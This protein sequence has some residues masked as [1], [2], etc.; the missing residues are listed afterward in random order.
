[1]VNNDLIESINNKTM[2][3]FRNIEYQSGDKV[4]VSGHYASYK[5]Q[6][7]FMVGK[8]YLDKKGVPRVYLDINPNDIRQTN[9]I[10]LN[11]Y[12][13]ISKI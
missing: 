13:D 8:V 5:S 11:C 6:Y 9:G 7:N 1:M 3:L 10:E 2:F 12:E 4:K